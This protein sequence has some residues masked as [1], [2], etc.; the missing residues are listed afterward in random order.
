MATLEQI[1]EAIKRADAS[2][3]AEDVKALA[4]AYRALQQQPAADAGPITLSGKVEA[5][6]SSGEVSANLEDRTP[7]PPPPSVG[8]KLMN[9][10]GATV[11][12]IVNGIPILGPMAQNTTDAIGGLISMATG[13][14]YDEYVNRQRKVREGYAEAAPVA[15][16]AG[17]LAGGIGAYGALAKVPAAASALGLTGGF[18]SRVANSTMSGAAIGAGDEFARGGDV[19]DMTASGLAGGAIGGIIP[20]V[21]AGLQKAAGAVGDAV[22]PYVN[23]ALDPVEEGSRRAG[24]AF[25]RDAKVNPGGWNAADEAA[26]RAS[27]VP[28][29]NVDRGGETVRALA[30]SVG[31]QSPEARAIIAKTADDR[32]VG[33]AQRATEIVK[34]VAGGSVDDLGYQQAIKDAARVANKPRYEAAYS[35][36]AA[37]AVWSKDIAE[38]MQSDTFRSAVN[39]AES[40]GTDKAAISGFKAVKNPFDFLPD[41]TVTLKTNA[42]GTRALPS[43]QFWDQVKRNIDGMIGT[44]QRAGDNEL[45]SVLT[46]IKQKL[47]GALD[48][49]VPEYKSARAGAAAFFDAED[50]LD[51]GR[52]FAMNNRMVPEARAAFMQFAPAEKAAFRTGYASSL[53]DK[54]MSASD[55]QNVINSTF[56]SPASREMMELVFGKAKAAE[57]EA[58]VRVESLVDMLRGA[59][60]NSTTAR[61]LMELGIGGASGFALT[62]DWKGAAAGLALSAAPRAIGRKLDSRVMEAVAK[63]LTSDNPQAV[64]TAVQNALKSPAYMR[65]I[66]DLSAK[67]APMARGAAVT[68]NQ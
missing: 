27:G 18:G 22:A 37:K 25:A 65:A 43:L 32:F 36:P 2:G 44:A 45:T 63:L 41:G 6:G 48:A 38:L 14:D 5:R 57:I 3:N 35:S 58:Y 50:A 24:M 16:V 19:F 64:K 12:G 1:A 33:Q 31:N 53:I 34:K 60:G 15:S 46:A 68:A 39:A 54:I 8:D 10:T 7:A 23:A 47:V 52:K 56:K 62:G 17:N 59:M 66:E 9:A 28:V 55:R 13:G 29:L 61:Q 49:T 26:A 4:T 30:R 67:L 40:R 11:N 51:A 21:G 42:D 20:V